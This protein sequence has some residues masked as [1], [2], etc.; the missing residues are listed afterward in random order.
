MKKLSRSERKN[1]MG[2]AAPVDG[3]AYQ[4]DSDCP[5]RESVCGGEITT[6]LGKYQANPGA[7][8]NICHWAGCP[9]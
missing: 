4:S 6:Y 1:V 5:R 7:T 3:L 9:Y 2:G 8:S